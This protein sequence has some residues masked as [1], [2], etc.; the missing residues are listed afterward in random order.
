MA[1]TYPS[2]YEEFKAKAQTLIENEQ[3]PVLC[4]H[5]EP[6]SGKI[7]LTAGSESTKKL[8]ESNVMIKLEEILKSTEVAKTFLAPKAASKIS[9]RSY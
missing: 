9:I 6:K 4:L 7:H 1:T 3:T 2:R 5:L 8:I